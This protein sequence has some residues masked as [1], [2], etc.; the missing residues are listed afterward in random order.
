MRDFR[1]LLQTDIVDSTRLTEPLGDEKAAALW[2]AHD[3]I[4]RTLIHLQHS[5]R[6]DSV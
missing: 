1:A 3:R 4:A 5:F 2:E 6:F